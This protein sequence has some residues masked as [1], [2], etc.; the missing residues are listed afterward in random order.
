MYPDS[1]SG[2]APKWRVIK[3]RVNKLVSIMGSNLSVITFSCMCPI[4]WYPR[5]SID[6]NSNSFFEG[7]D[8]FT[9]RPSFFKFLQS[10]S[11]LLYYLD[12][13]HYLLVRVSGAAILKFLRIMETTFLC[14]PN[15]I[16]T[17]FFENL[18]MKDRQSLALTNE[19]LCEIERK[20]GGRRFNK[21]SF[22]NVCLWNI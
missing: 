19:R 6:L 13:T 9:L 1:P 4:I 22:N 5:P 10:L 11:S 20:S 7:L 8:L 18:S 15:E 16:M 12:W 2:K 3:T 17:T 21:I 14:L